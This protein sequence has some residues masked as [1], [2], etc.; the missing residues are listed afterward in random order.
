M[1]LSW[2]YLSMFYDLKIVHENF[3]IVNDLRTLLHRYS[4][5]NRSVMCALIDL[6]LCMCI[7]LIKHQV[8]DN[9]RIKNNI[10]ICFKKMQGAYERRQLV[11]FRWNRRG[12]ADHYWSSVTVTRRFVPPFSVFCVC[13][14][15]RKHI[16]IKWNLVIK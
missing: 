14:T 12:C 1:F 10:L 15:Y 13:L 16:H 9:L 3:F 7:K 2:D 6:L 8:D 11:G 5:L 4:V